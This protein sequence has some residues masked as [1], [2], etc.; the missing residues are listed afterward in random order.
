MKR[1]AV[2][3]AQRI[4]W[5][6]TM[7]ALAILMVVIIHS[8]APVLYNWNEVLA[9]NIPIPSWNFANILNSISRI[10]IPIFVMLSGTFLLRSPENLQT[11]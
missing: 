11:F 3:T 8:S 7:R 6:D 1:T 4:F 2:N 9:S 5:A 10:S